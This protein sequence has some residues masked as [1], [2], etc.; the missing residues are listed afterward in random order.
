MSLAYIFCAAPAYRAGAAVSG[1]TS[2]SQ[3]RLS[4]SAEDS[5]RQRFRSPT[6]PMRD[7]EWPRLTWGRQ[8]WGVTSVLF[9]TRLLGAICAQWGCHRQFYSGGGDSHVIAEVELKKT[10]PL[11]LHLGF[12]AEKRLKEGSLNIGG[13]Y[14]TGWKWFRRPRRVEHPPVILFPYHLLPTSVLRHLHQEHWKHQAGACIW[15]PLPLPNAWYSTKHRSHWSQRSEALRLRI[16]FLNHA[17]RDFFSFCS[18]SL[19]H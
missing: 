5:V 14:G 15:N 4:P 6:S 17:L 11:T 13:C 1:R 8:W 3:T 7:G 16:V 2:H 18:I 10:A 12:V 9:Q 19:T